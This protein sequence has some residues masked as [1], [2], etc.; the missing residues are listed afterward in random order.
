ML[1]FT[2]TNDESV[3]PAPL[4]SSGMQHR[5]GHR[6]RTQR[7]T[8]DC[9]KFNVLGDVQHDPADQRRS[10]CIQ[11]DTSKVDVV[12]GFT[13]GRQNHFAVNNSFIE[14]FLAQGIAV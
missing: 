9:I 4:R 2:L 6:V 3:K 5:S 7:E 13:P 12:I 10:H 14:D 1:L 8:T 11:R